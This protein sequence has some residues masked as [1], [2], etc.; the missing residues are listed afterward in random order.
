MLNKLA[1]KKI[2]PFTHQFM[3]YN[4]NKLVY[5]YW[6][7]L[8]LKYEQKNITSYLYIEINLYVQA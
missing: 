3:I 7:L 2:N 4:T 6:I 5:I 8:P 1:Y